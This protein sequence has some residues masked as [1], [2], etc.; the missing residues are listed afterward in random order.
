MYNNFHWLFK[1]SLVII[2][3]IAV[4]VKTEEWSAGFQATANF[5]Q[6]WQQFEIKHGNEDAL[7]EML[8]IKRSVQAIYNTQVIPGVPWSLCNKATVFATLSWVRVP[9]LDYIFCE[10]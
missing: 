3:F 7:R 8:R 4:L 2:Q 5:W 6:T 1:W 9:T 10:I